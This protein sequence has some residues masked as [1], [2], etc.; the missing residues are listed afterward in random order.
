MAVNDPN[1]PKVEK[2]IVSYVID[3][4]GEAIPMMTASLCSIVEVRDVT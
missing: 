1:S 3:E 2:A 4:C